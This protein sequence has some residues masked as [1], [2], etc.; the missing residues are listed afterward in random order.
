MGFKARKCLFCG[1]TCLKINEVAGSDPGNANSEGRDKQ[2]VIFQDLALQSRN[3][4]AHSDCS[5]G[6]KSSI[7][8]TELSS[9]SSRKAREKP[10]LLITVAVPFPKL[11]ADS[12]RPM[13]FGT[14]TAELPWL[15]FNQRVIRYTRHTVRLAYV[16][17]IQV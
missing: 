16:H 7:G 10:S 1:H 12:L 8:A 15:D 6:N 5:K 14:R 13:C 9:W 4:S 3:K 11:I 2:K 17:L